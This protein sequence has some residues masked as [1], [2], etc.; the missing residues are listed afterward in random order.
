MKRQRR[1]QFLIFI[2]SLLL[3]GLG[4]TIVWMIYEA[5]QVEPE[6]TGRDPSFAYTPIPTRVLIPFFAGLA[7]SIAMVIV[8]VVQRTSS[9][10]SN[11]T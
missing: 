7:A 2:V 6:F 8:R 3:L 11:E 5:T 1:A 9:A 4:L 10:D